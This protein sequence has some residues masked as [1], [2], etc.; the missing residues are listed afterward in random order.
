MRHHNIFVKSVFARNQNYIWMICFSPTVGHMTY[1][2]ISFFFQLALD[3]HRW[4][5]LPSV[6]TGNRGASDVT[7]NV[8]PPYVLME[9]PP[10]AAFV[11][12]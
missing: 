1:L 7:D 10:L 5:A 6:G 8:S 12:G 9:H 4:I 11:N 2:C 3:S